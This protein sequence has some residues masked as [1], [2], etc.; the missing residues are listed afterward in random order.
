MGLSLKQERP[1]SLE[2]VGSNLV[3]DKATVWGKTT[4]TFMGERI[5]ETG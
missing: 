2:G 1:P 5:S 4:Q 3:Q